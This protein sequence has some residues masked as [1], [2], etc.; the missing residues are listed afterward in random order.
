MNVRVVFGYVFFLLSV[1]FCAFQL[2]T[3]PRAEQPAV[4]PVGLQFTSVLACLLLASLAAQRGHRVANLAVAVVA[5][6]VCALALLVAGT[7][8]MGE[9]DKAVPI[10]YAVLLAHA[11]LYGFCGLVF[12]L[13][14]GKPADGEARKDA[15]RPQ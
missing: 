2:V 12:S 10:K 9:T 11:G 8:A 13:L 5:F 4:V 7:L 15:V 14:A 6:S 1:V 3:L